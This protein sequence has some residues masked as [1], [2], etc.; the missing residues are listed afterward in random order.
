MVETQTEK[1]APTEA[2]WLGFSP[3]IKVEKNTEHFVEILSMSS[4]CYLYVSTIG[5]FLS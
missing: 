3:G 2:I 5:R 1:K 4:L